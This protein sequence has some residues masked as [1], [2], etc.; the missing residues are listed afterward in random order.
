MTDESPATGEIASEDG[1]LGIEP[2]LPLARIGSAARIAVPV[3]YLLVPI[4]WDPQNRYDVLYCN[5][6]TQ[7]VIVRSESR[8]L[9]FLTALSR[10]LTVALFSAV[11]EMDRGQTLT[12]CVSLI[13]ATPRLP[14]CPYSTTRVTALQRSLAP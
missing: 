8:R 9:H 6:L 4:R 3:L 14:V 11:P 10:R 2:R 5:L 12:G 7:R 13:D 1:V